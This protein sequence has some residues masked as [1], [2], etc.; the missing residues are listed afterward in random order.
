[1]T[2]DQALYDVTIIGGGPTGLFT[3]FYAG[4]RQMK[5]KIIE[6]LP[7]LGG[8]LGTLYPEKDIFDV[9]GFPRVK[10]KDL[11]K[12]LIGQAGQFHPTMILGENVNALHKMDDGTIVLE[13]ESGASHRTKTVIIAAGVG[14]FSPRPLKVEGAEKY[15]QTNLH[16]YV[17]DVQKFKN[18]K[19]VILGGGDSAVDWANTLEAIADEVTIVHRR[20]AFRAHETTV[21]RMKDSSIKVLTP[22]TAKAIEGADGVI[23]RLIV[24]EVKGTREENLPLDD[25]IVNY[26][27]VSAL[28]P[29]KDW[30]LELDK[31]SIVVNSKMETNIPGVYAAGDVA[32]YPGKVKL[33]ASGFG[34]APTAVNNA[35]HYIDPDSRTQPMHSSSAE[36]LFSK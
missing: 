20:N 9:A 2:E 15:E 29:I 32:A 6:N 16:Y 14:A 25:L 36:E 34:E 19:V 28:G 5:V 7:Q 10:A 12:R 4:L 30:G 31:N 21:Q 35:K 3:A 13:S 17:N 26:G 1:M 33:I 27:F 8:Q 11:V 18:K 23:K 22:F 24:S